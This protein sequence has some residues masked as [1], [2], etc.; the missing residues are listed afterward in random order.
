MKIQTN[1]NIYEISQKGGDIYIRANNRL[2]YISKNSADF[3]EQEHP[4]DKSGQFVKKG[5]EQDSEKQ[6]YEKQDF[7]KKS[8]SPKSLKD[9]YKDAL[10]KSQGYKYKKVIG[11]KVDIEYIK[12]G[13]KKVQKMSIPDS[14]SDYD[15]Y[16]Q[17]HLNS[18]ML[19]SK[20]KGNLKI[21]KIEDDI[22]EKEATPE[23]VFFQKQKAEELKKAI[24]QNINV[25][26]Y[27]ELKE[28]QRNI[29]ITKEHKAEKNRQEYYK[30]IKESADLGYIQSRTKDKVVSENYPDIVDYSIISKV[31]RDELKKDG[32]K[33][34]YSSGKNVSESSQY[35][36]KDGET[37]RLSDHKL[38]QTEERKDATK[39]GI[40]K[41]WDKEIILSPYRL[42][43]LIK[44]K[45][46]QDV[47]KKL[48]S[49]AQKGNE[50]D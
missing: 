23:Q 14:V 31:L 25:S 34:Y 38:P 8:I 7:V 3:K 6:D 49:F 43:D 37:I 9:E 28:Q 32:W 19:R 17:E 5:E 18:G 40:R 13:D 33:P 44:E 11:K 26:S 50:F 27:K 2:L 1:K 41:G 47:M 15:K 16:I 35:F 12:N 21:G 10:E 45:D 20:E 30:E 22:I 29:E 4:R 46:R 42:V 39:S 24:E 48:F 36:E